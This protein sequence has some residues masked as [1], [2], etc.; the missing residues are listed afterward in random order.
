MT[1]AP[2]VIVAGGGPA[3]AWAAYLLARA[4]VSV[5]VFERDRFPRPKLCGDTLNPGA[6]ALLAQHLDVGALVPYAVQL[7]GMLLSGPGPVLVRGEYGAGVHALGVSRDVLDAW[8]IDHA[9]RAGAH[10][11]EEAT[12]LGPCVDAAG[13]VAG[14]RVR[15]RGGRESSHAARL[16]LAADGR[17]SRLGEACR[18]SRCAAHPRRWAVGAYFDAAT[19]LTAFGEMHVRDGYYIGVAPTADDRAN[20]CLVQPKEGEGWRAPATLLRDRLLS[21]P[22]LGPRFTHAVATTPTRVLGPLAIETP[23]PG[24]A[25]L[26]L[27]GDAAGF[28]DPMTGDGIRLALS[29][30][31]AAATIA[32]SVLDGHQDAHTAYRVYAKAL[33]QQVQAKRLFNRAM[34]ALVASPRAV[35]LAARATAIW[36]GPLRAAISVAGDAALARA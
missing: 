29:S 19:G 14:V 5:T 23:T 16:T 36:P 32:A 28:I 30:A 31:A 21:D 13:R 24:C 18:L 3:G 8:L 27:L 22:V 34:R 6:V 25:G 12:V 15:Q 9:V 17:R 20:V 1:R 26:L 2:D 11:V 35:A 4:G 7:D 10:L 33:R